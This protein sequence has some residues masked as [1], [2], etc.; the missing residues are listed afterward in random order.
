[1]AE[2]ETK[3]WGA[4]YSLFEKGFLPI[5]RSERKKPASCQC[6][7]GKEK[8][9]PEKGRQIKPRKNVGSQKGK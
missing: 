7:Y 3:N 5:S 6:P 8:L 1:V 9:G 4:F 2:E